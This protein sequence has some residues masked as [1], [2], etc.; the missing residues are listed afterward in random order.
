MLIKI[1]TLDLAIF[2]VLSITVT[3]S[4]QTTTHFPLEGFSR[5]TIIYYYYTYVYLKKKCESSVTSILKDK[6]KIVYSV[7]ILP[8]HVSFNFTVLKLNVNGI[9]LKTVNIA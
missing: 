8:R 9:L 7:S 2:V 4:L 1:Y 3:I 5:R 6:N